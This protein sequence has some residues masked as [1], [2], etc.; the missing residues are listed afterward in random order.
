M[1]IKKILLWYLFAAVLILS[2]KAP[3]QEQRKPEETDAD[4]RTAK[5][6]IETR[7]GK[8]DLE[9]LVFLV[10]ASAQKNV[11]P[12]AFS[13]LWG[14]PA[15]NVYAYRTWKEED[16]RGWENL[17]RSQNMPMPEKI[18]PHPEILI[19]VSDYYGSPRFEVTYWTDDKSPVKIAIFF[20]RG[21]YSQELVR[22]PRVDSLQGQDFLD[23]WRNLKLENERTKLELAWRLI[24]TSP[25]NAKLEFLLQDQRRVETLYQCLSNQFVNRKAELDEERE[26]LR[27][28]LDGGAID[29]KQYEER[30][31]VVADNLSALE[32]DVKSHSNEIKAWADFLF[33]YELLANK[34]LYKA[35]GK[36]SPIDPVSVKPSLL[37]QEMEHFDSVKNYVRHML[38]KW[39]PNVADLYDS[40]WQKY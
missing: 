15:Q 23:G 24:L 8:R 17:L 11:G 13:A 18:V 2:P 16:L 19:I 6:N 40:Y 33:D 36:L 27:K 12:N 35:A 34:A 26:A 7:E 1:L 21:F 32:K 39:Y 38:H 22:S 29:E 30:L 20:N 31:A 28:K 5:I 25:Q 37:P 4:S 14:V 9:A 3:A 10:A